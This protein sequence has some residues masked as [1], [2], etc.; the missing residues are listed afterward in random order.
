MKHLLFISLFVASFLTISEA[1]SHRRFSLSFE[2]QRAKFDMSEGSIITRGMS[3]GFTRA[4]ALSRRMP[5]GLDLTGKL[6]WT[7][8]VDKATYT[9]TRTDFLS[10]QFPVSLTWRFSLFNGNL[11]V[12]PFIGPSFRFNL[13]GSMRSLVDLPQER[14]RTSINLLSR[15]RR[16][17]AKIFQF[18]MNMG[19][20]IFVHNFY[21]GYMFQPNFTP[22]IED[23]RGTYHVKYEEGDLKSRSHTVTLAYVF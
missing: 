22:Y 14:T 10:A 6:A 12:A 5:L 16:T 4:V 23:A 20:G 2:S 3:L 7:H 1:Q 15:E 8:G 13:I 9:T 21:F 19:G 17:P 11:G 18:G